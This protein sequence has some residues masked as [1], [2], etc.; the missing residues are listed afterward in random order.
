M[1]VVYNVVGEKADLLL[2]T[3]EK[4]KKLPPQKGADL[5][6]FCRLGG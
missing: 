2:S 3:S 1:Y 6:T 5:L 4:Q